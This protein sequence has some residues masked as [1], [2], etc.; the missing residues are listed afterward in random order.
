MATIDAFI[1]LLFEKLLSNKYTKNRFA[2]TNLSK[3]KE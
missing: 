2:S 1:E 3:V